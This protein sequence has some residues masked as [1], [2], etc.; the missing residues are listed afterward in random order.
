MR[1]LSFTALFI[2]SFAL[3]WWFVLIL[4]VVYAFRYCAYELIVLGVLLDAVYGGALSSH[5]VP[6]VYTLTMTVI[7]FVVEILKPHLSLYKERYE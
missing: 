7:I 3:P 5:I 6:V 1:A 4:S 2:L